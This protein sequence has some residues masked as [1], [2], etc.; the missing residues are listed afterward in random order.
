M[1]KISVYIII[2]F[3][4]V[5]LLPV[6]CK[7]HPAT[8]HPAVQAAEEIYTCPMHPQVIEHHPGNCPICGMTLVKKEFTAAEAK[9]A[10]V[11]LHTLLRPTNSAVVSGIPV[12]TLQQA[13]PSLSIDALGRVD[14]DT[15]RVQTI[16]A[17]VSGRIEKLYV[18]Y[19]YQHVHMGD[20]I[21]DIYSPELVTAQQDLL[22]ILH[23]DPGNAALLEAAR[24]KLQLLGMDAQQLQQVIQSGKPSYKVTVYTHYTGHIHEAGNM[25][26]ASGG[27]QTMDVSKEMAEL[28]IKEGMY[29]QKGQTVFQ[30]YNTDQSW[31]ILNVFA[32]SSSLVKS[33][34]SVTIT[35]ETAPDKPFQTTISYIEPFYRD[36]SKTLTAR[37]YFDNASRQLPI[38]GQVKATI[39]IQTGPGA[40]LPREAV[41]SL[42][43]HQVVLKRENGLFQVSAVQ[44]SITT[45]SLIQIIGGLSAQDS[46]AADAQFL[47][48]SESF[49][50][51]KGSL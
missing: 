6:A 39:R 35:P 9:N 51:V 25:A 8:P 21:M 18:K 33:G 19:R 2:V 7:N 14:Y 20:K 13:S 11:D 24:T 3:V 37:V 26:E 23:N 40:W 45:D 31:I 30:L 15:R 48:D 43:L 32:G 28:P 22:F 5:G 41:L 34:S 42:G 10:T 4:S 49:I 29:V 17:R 36:N 46:V 12:I 38:G 1:K 47:M 44:T 27:L 50:K 16:A